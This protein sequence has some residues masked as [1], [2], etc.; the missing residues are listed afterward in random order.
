MKPYG[1]IIFL[2]NP[3]TAGVTIYNLLRRKQILAHP[4]S[5][6]NLQRARGFGTYR[7]ED[8]VR[9]LEELTTRQ[10][11]AVRFCHGHFGYGIHEYFRIPHFYLSVFRD[12]VARAYSAYRYVLG[13]FGSNALPE[14]TN[15]R[16]A[17]KLGPQMRKFM[18]DNQYVRFMAGSKGEII[19]NEPVTRTM[20]DV[21]VER[22]NE[23][24]DVVGLQEQFVET[25]LLLGR[26]CQWRSTTFSSYNKTDKM[27][28]RTKAPPL[29]DE[30]REALADANELD[31]EF[32]E[33]AKKRF[34]RDIERYGV[35]KMNADVRE[36]EIKSQRDAWRN[37]LTDNLSRRVGHT[38]RRLTGSG[39]SPDGPSS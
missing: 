30:D 3:K 23:K 16:D 10:Q 26:R 19:F 20:L 4:P 7:F 32:Y 34:R 21:A 2:H 8:R 13:G 17:I 18:L 31:L 25:V 11:R 24:I 6:L 33:H 36:H 1:A 12:P 38:I 9:M 22:L 29:T 37:T 39:R 35:N 15:V 27:R 5:W 28:I 14:G